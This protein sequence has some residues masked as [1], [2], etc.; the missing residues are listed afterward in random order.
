MKRI[1]I[2]AMFIALSSF[3]FAQTYMSVWKNGVKMDIQIS[4]I[5][6][7]TFGDTETSNGIGIFSVS[8]NDKVTFSKGNL[9]YHPKKNKWQFANN[10]YDYFGEA[11]E[12]I[13]ADYNGWID[14]FGWGTGNNPTEASS[15]SSKYETFTDWGINK[16]GDDAPNTWR[17]LTRA[18]WEYLL[19][20]RPKASTL[21]CYGAIITGSNIYEY[22]SGLILLPDNWVTPDSIPLVPGKDEQ[23]KFTLNQWSVLE[24]SG[25]VF[26]PEAGYRISATKVLTSYGGYY[27]TATK[28]NYSSYDSYAYSLK[29]DYPL[30]LEVNEKENYRYQ[31][32]SVRLVKDL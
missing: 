30:Y 20:S 22:E 9:Q 6:S 14:L 12:N 32:C 17:T 25:A 10:Q 18:E 13:S 4:A 31:G 3:I 8:P 5:D 16:I 24:L 29:I 19:E 23:Q 11:N 26:L 7:I 15:S 2:C 27:W 21:L 28:S 1:T